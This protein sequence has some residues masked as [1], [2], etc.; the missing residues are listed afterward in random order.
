MIIVWRILYLTMLARECPDASCDIV[1][2]DEEWKMAYT[3]KYRKKAPDKPIS[4]RTMMSLIAQFGGYLARKYN[5]EP[6]PT[7]VWIGLQRLRD[8]LEVKHAYDT[9]KTYG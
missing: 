2:T 8:F 5:C 1:F 6:G 9:I 7:A 3:V 4:L